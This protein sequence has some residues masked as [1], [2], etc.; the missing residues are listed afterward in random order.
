M[1]SVPSFVLYGFF[2]SY[3]LVFSPG[4]LNYG[5]WE[6]SVESVMEGLEGLISSKI[7]DCMEYDWATL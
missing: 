4:V 3:V 7:M 1:L 5:T 2:F 6:K